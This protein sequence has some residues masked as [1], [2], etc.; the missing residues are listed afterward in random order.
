MLVPLPLPLPPL[1][2]A[3]KAHSPPGPAGFVYLILMKVILLKKI[4]IRTVNWKQLPFPFGNLKTL[5]GKILIEITGLGL[6]PRRVSLKPCPQKQFSC[7]N[8]WLIFM[9]QIYFLKSWLNGF[10]ATK[11]VTNEKLLM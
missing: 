4:S 3:K 7:E 8:S 9:S 1:S 2:S 6:E 5:L 10:Y 11:V